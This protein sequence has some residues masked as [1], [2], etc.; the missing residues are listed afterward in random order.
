LEF[1]QGFS[2]GLHKEV[3]SIRSVEREKFLKLDA[4]KQ[5]KKGGVL[6]RYRESTVVSHP[7][8][9][10]ENRGGESTL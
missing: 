3:R 4:Q 8:R 6:N 7:H 1:N 2:A 5:H 9:G 10:S